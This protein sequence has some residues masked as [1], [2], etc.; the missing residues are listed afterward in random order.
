MKEILFQ[1]HYEKRVCVA[2]YI[3]PPFCFHFVVRYKHELISLV[4][5]STNN[6]SNFIHLD[7]D[8]DEETDKLLGVEHR[9]NAKNQAIRDT[10]C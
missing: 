10:V 4:L 5:Y 3:F 8:T 7:Y 9:I 6:S 1:N 2:C